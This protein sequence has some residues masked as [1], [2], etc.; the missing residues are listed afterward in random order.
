MRLMILGA[1]NCQLNLIKRAKIR[2]HYVIV[3]DYLD[4]PPGAKFADVHIK[5]STFDTGLVMQAAVE[6]EIEGIVTLGTDQPVLTAA[7]VAKKLGLHF[8]AGSYLALAVT[9]KRIMKELFAKNKIPMNDYRLIGKGFAK[10]EIKGLKFPAVLKPVDSQGQRGIFKVRNI[11][12]V[13]RHIE[14]TLSYSREDKVLLEEFYRSDEIT[15]NGWAANGR[16]KIISVVDRLTMKKTN[17]IGICIGH[18][19]PSL[20]LRG[21]FEDIERI[22]QDIVD[23]FGITDGPIY[24]QYLI[25]NKGVRVNEIAMRIGGAY[26]DLTIPIISGI[27]IAGM[28]LDYIETGSC[29]NKTLEEYSLLENTK[30]VSTQMFFLKPGKITRMTPL[31]EVMQ[32][33]GVKDVYYAVKEGD[34]AAGIKN[35]TA[36]AGYVIIE[37]ENFDELKAKIDRLYENMKVFDESGKNLVISFNEYKDK[38]LFV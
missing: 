29:D 9:N 25:G 15:V 4:N 5:V 7:I 16:A 24:F 26:E 38:Y 37:G 10:E 31:E 23:A 1:G 14:E 35:A 11:E 2:G 34:I 13:S 8:Y 21:Y 19:F 36:R 32:L 17:R 28:L 3:A 30:Y 22:T 27:D 12:E 20:H 6:Y 18:N 33:D